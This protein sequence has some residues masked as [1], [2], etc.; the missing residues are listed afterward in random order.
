MKALL[1]ALVIAAATLPSAA[2]P[3]EVWIAKPLSTKFVFG[4]VD[5]EA[6]VQSEERVAAVELYLDGVKLGELVSP[7]YRLTVDVGFDN[8]EHEFK[9]VAR[10][11][12]GKTASAVMITAA[13][14]VDD[15]V[16]VELQQLYVTVGEFDRRVLDLERDDFRIF[17]DGERQEIVT[18]ERGDVPL[19][20]TV[21][22]DCS[23]SMQGERLAAALA[24][25][26]V[27]IGGMNP[28]DRVMVMLFSD[29]LLR[30]TEFSDNPQALVPAL[31]NL[32]A[33]GGTSINDHLFM[34]L[35]RLELEQGRRVVVLFSDGSDV[36]SV[37][38][39]A[40]VLQKARS[41]QALVYWI[42]LRDPNDDDEIPSYTS[43][44][45]GVEANREEFRRLRE[46]VRESGG[47]T[48]VVESIGEL[49]DAFAGII[50]ELREQYVIGYY[51]SQDL[52]DGSWHDVKVRVQRPE[53][54]VR[55]R[56][57][58]FDY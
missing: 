32:E 54:K 49:T 35:A 33:S 21:L 20:A 16:E 1:T 9:A 4:D 52:G 41:S 22:L 50:A 44:W 47:R 25:A 8:V 19:T 3:I 46:A 28:L 40:D 17:D 5:F 45:R 56:E 53:V 57:G 37:L 7:P 39:M 38:P 58:Y 43:S 2:A 10:T 24:G 34:S 6:S 18:F 51:P 11:V 13:L 15:V 31:T 14:H 36:H 26:K 27:F 55:T 23:L 42:H 12:S 29:R 48:E 30:A